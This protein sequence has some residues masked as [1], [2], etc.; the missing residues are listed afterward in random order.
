LIFKKNLGKSVEWTPMRPEVYAREMFPASENS[1]DNRK[2]AKEYLKH[3][4]L[5]YDEWIAKYK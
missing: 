4:S 2:T 5:T 3:N 1:W